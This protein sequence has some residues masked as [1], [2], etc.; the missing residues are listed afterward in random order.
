MVLPVQAKVSALSTFKAGQVQLWCQGVVQ[1]LSR[2]QLL[3]PH[4]LQPTSIL[5]P[6]DFPGKSTGVDCHFF[7]QGIVP[8]QK[9]NLGLLHCRQILYQLSC[10]GSPPF[11]NLYNIIYQYVLV[12]LEYLYNNYMSF[13]QNI[14][15][16]KFLKF[17]PQ[18]LFL[19]VLRASM[20]N[21]KSYTDQK[22]FS[23]L[24]FTPL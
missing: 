21:F 23:L 1:S 20:C 19:E 2:V 11:L 17:V 8:T 6:W 5:C 13:T 18:P 12:K 9:S 4:G 10:E 22:V 24:F 7:L 3:Q 14:L 15:A 16:V